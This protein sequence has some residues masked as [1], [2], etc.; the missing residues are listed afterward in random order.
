MALTV[1]NMSWAYVY[2]ALYFLYLMQAVYKLRTLP[3][4]DHKMSNLMV[5]LQARLDFFVL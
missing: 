5:R 2:F 1:L 3:R 4:Q